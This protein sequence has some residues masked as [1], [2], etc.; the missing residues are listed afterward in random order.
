MTSEAGKVAKVS[1]CIVTYNQE[2]YIAQCLQSIVDQQTDFNFEIIVSDDCSKDNTPS[3]ISEFASKYNNIRFIK[4]TQNV[5]AFK[6]SSE[7]HKEAIGQYVCHCDGDDYWLPEKLQTQS[8]YLDEHLTCNVLFTRVCVESENGKLKPDLI[9]INKFPKNG[10]SQGDILR[11]ISIGTNSSKMYR[12]LESQKY[13]NLPILDFFETV[14]QVGSGVANYPND[15][16]YAVYRAGIGIASQ[17]L[18]TRKALHET[19]LYFAKKYP[20]HKQHINVAAFIL[21]TSDLKNR[22]PTWMAGFGVFL[23]TFH[24]GFIKLL[25]SSRYMIK[26]LK[27]P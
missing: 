17:G 21:F 19:F 5:G 8:D 1:V 13:P 26:M 9:D 14:E 23:K 27:N 16:F 20:N 12:S 25:F 11:L 6:N 10:F 2:K 18:S 22:R 3:I 4:R 24:P 7:T 15:H